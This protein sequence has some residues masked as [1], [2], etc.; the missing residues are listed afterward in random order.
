MKFVGLSLIEASKW[1]KKLRPLINKAYAHLAELGHPVSPPDPIMSVGVANLE[2]EEDVD[3]LAAELKICIRGEDTRWS[4]RNLKFAAV[5]M[6]LGAGT[7]ICDQNRIQRLLVKI[8][9]VGDTLTV[10]VLWKGETIST[11]NMSDKEV[12]DGDIAEVN[13]RIDNFCEMASTQIGI[14]E[15]TGDTGA[16]AKSIRR[17]ISKEIRKRVVDPMLNRMTH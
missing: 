9:K 12:R 7:L 11:L 2:T 3:L 10:R 4:G 6:Q 14:D 5:L 13:E 8:D 16:S 17:A 1:A 15:T